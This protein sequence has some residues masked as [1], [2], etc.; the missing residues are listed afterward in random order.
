MVRKQDKVWVK[1]LSLVLELVLKDLKKN[2][3][4]KEINDETRINL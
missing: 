3:E 4:V 2:I 1:E